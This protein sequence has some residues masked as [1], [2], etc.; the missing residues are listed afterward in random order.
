MKSEASIE[1]K[2]R[3]GTLRSLEILDTEPEQQF[4]DV[5]TLAS[6]ILDVPVALITFVDLNRV[7][8][9][10]RIGLET[11]EVERGSW[12]CDTAILGQNILA[13]ADAALDDRFKNHPFVVSG[14]KFRFYAGVPLVLPEGEAVGTLCVLDT[15]PRSLTERQTD[16]LK[17]LGRQ[18]S[19]LLRARGSLAALTRDL[20]LNRELAG[21]AVKVRTSFLAN[22]SHEIRTPMTAILGMADLLLGTELKKDQREYLDT[23]RSSGESLLNT[24]NDI[25]DFSKIESGSLEL[26]VQPF[27]LR[28]CVEESLEIVTPRAR[29]QGNEIMYVIDASV[30]H[31][32]TGDAGRIQQ[33]LVNLIN[34]AVK[35]T[36]NGE[37][38]LSIKV[39][40]RTDNEIGLVFRLKDT[41]IGIPQDKRDMIF[42]AFTQADS[43]VTRKYGGTGLGLVICARLVGLMGGQ[44][45]VESSEGAGSEFF[46][47][48]RTSVPA[49]QAPVHVPERS[50]DLKG[51]RVLLVDDSPTTLKILSA[52]CEQ[53]GMIP[54]LASSPAEALRLLATDEKIDVAIY[55][56][57]M[58]EKDGVQLASETKELRT[59]NPFPIVLLSSWDLSDPR[60]KQHHSL[61]AA[62]VMKPLKISQFHS[63]LSDVIATKG[64]PKPEGQKE[65]EHGGKL[66]SEYPVSIMV[67]EDN[68]INQKL[69]ERM[70]RSMGYEPHI[71]ETGLEAL[72]ALDQRPYD[73]I[74]MDVQ[75]PEMDGLEATQKIRQRRGEHEGPKVVAMTAFALAGDKEK[76]LKAGMNDYLSK[77]FVA[78]QVASMIRKW[79]R[80]GKI[81]ATP[82]ENKPDTPEVL[83]DAD[84]QVRLKE[85]EQETEPA[86]VRE[87][88]GI[89][90]EEAPEN[91]Q[92]LKDARRAKNREL[93]EQTA[94]KLKGS[95][96]NLGAVRLSR[97]FERVEE[98]SRKGI[99]SVSDSEIADIDGEFDRTLTL[100]RAH[101]AALRGT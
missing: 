91:L 42:E 66:S 94:H 83:N 10:S 90:L 17:T 31:R 73:L 57:Q 101:A 77:P 20:T 18:V 93:L 65:P 43:S 5:S 14:P 75:M 49:E 80:P 82:A 27:D 76:C 11:S 67:A 70:L 92:K 39:Q 29:L 37:I 32:I 48:L 78:D 34:N 55:D 4:D 58:P 7:W 74:F 46:F 97:H 62:T 60:I 81:P 28:A 52:E 15:K 24:I 68:F 84:I 53:W 99:G 98:R 6:S 3:L 12:F 35:F 23:I 26:D 85:L 2:K 1:E 87:L 56:M 40:Q 61:F 50:A 72:N 30:P 13:V 59:S 88:I 22:M 100:L 19:V 63:L 9:K 54:V 71:V 38:F 51:K 41:G 79:G 36:R 8:F 64:S 25:L 16:I 96:L 89:F 86:F 45:G 21:S 95:C 69:I 47:T 33:V 44:I